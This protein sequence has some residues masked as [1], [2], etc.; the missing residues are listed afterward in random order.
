MDWH[1]RTRCTLDIVTN[2]I[3][4]E[5]QKSH[6]VLTKMQRD[7]LYST[8]VLLLNQSSPG[9]CFEIC[10]LYKI[11]DF[12]LGGARIL[13]TPCVS[14]SNQPFSWQTYTRTPFV[15]NFTFTVAV[16]QV[17]SPFVHLCFDL[18]VMLV[19]S[20][21]CYFLISELIWGRSQLQLFIDCW[22][23]PDS[24]HLDWP[25]PKILFESEMPLGMFKKFIGWIF[26]MWLSGAHRCVSASPF[27]RAP[28]VNGGYVVPQQDT[29]S[30]G[31]A[32][33]YACDNG[34]KPAVEG[35]WATTTCHNG[36]WSTRPQCIG[37]C[38]THR[39]P[40]GCWFVLMGAD[41]PGSNLNKIPNVGSKMCQIFDLKCEHSF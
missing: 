34:F 15:G 25:P 33:P 13:Q 27:C 29:Y 3:S 7:V 8:F 20:H 35:W 31:T 1:F 39:R 28:V 22:P 17:P 12:F 19:L 26:M 10:P 18:W 38:W 30:H 4:P 5:T 40:E 9:S 24:Q 11:I 21:V 41:G 6:T 23:Q 36:K 14:F 16:T 2:V 32:L 37:K